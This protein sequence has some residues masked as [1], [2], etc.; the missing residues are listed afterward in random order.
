MKSISATR[1]A[2]LLILGL[3]VTVSSAHGAV[4]GDLEDAKKGMKQA[5]KCHYDKALEKLDTAIA[6]GG[7]AAE[8]AAL[9][10]VV[11]LLDAGR[12][13]EAKEAMAERNKRA[14]ATPEEIAEAENSI[15]E[16]LENLR[17]EREKQTGSRTCP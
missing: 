10:K 12:E 17:A 7:F 15:A 13:D 11:V 4:I 9:E 6:E 3:A 14:G 5:I 1:R 16:T 2:A 8:L